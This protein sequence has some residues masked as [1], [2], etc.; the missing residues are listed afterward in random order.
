[1]DKSCCGAGSAWGS[2]TCGQLFAIIAR[3]GKTKCS[4]EDSV[5]WGNAA[6]LLQ[7]HTGKSMLRSILF[8]E[9]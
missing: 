3:G 5:Y 2:P 1:M 9:Q 4:S 7:I 8:A 6:A